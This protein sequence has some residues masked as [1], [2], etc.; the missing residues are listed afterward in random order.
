MAILRFLCTTTGNQTG[1]SRCLFF[2]KL[3]SL[4][5]PGYK[6]SGGFSIVQCEPLAVPPS[7]PVPAPAYLI[8]FSASKLEKK[9]VGS[10][11]PFFEVSVKRPGPTARSIKLVRSTVRNETTEPSWDPFVLC[12]QDVG[13]LDG[14]F[15]VS[16]YDWEKD[17]AHILIGELTI[18]LREF[19]F[20]PFQYPLINPDKVGR[21]AVN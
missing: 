8:G 19:I 16:C 5:R 21:Y 11:D 9:L 14:E 4:I 7:L 20:G 18:T 10:T 13:G 3:N 12:T 17:G 2:P 15:T 1:S 6:S